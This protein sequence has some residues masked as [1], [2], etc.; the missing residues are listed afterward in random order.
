MMLRGWCLCTSEYSRSQGRQL[1]NE[2]QSF[3]YQTHHFIFDL[4]AL[5]GL[6]ILL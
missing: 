2:L 1:A 6:L 3:E 5:M 4:A